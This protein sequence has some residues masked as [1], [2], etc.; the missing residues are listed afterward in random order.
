VGLLHASFNAPADLVEP[1]FDWVRYV[2]TMLLGLVAI[3]VL[4]SRRQERKL[5]RQRPGTG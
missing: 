2:V 4:V 3:T 1:G 5:P